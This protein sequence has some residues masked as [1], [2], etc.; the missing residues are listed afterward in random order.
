[1][2]LLFVTMV[3]ASVAAQKAA[4]V[5]P[6]QVGGVVETTPVAPQPDTAKI[7]AEVAQMTTALSELMASK[8]KLAAKK[9][10]LANQISDLQTKASALQTS[11]ETLEST[12]QEKEALAQESARQIE[13]LEKEKAE[14]DK[15]IAVI[16]NEEAERKRIDD[17]TKVIYQCSNPKD[18]YKVD[19]GVYKI[20]DSSC[21]L[22]VYL[23]DELHLYSVNRV[24]IREKDSQAVVF[25]R[26]MRKD[27]AFVRIPSASWYNKDKYPYSKEFII[28]VEYYYTSS[29]T[30]DQYQIDAM[31]FK[32]SRHAFAFQ[33]TAKIFTAWR[34]NETEGDASFLL[35]GVS[36]GAAWRFPNAEDDRDV[37]ALRAVLALGPN[38]LSKSVVGS[39]DSDDTTSTSFQIIGGFEFVVAQYLTIGAA[40][41]L[42]GSRADGAVSSNDPDPVPLLLVTYGELYPSL[43]STK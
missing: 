5:T 40:W 10:E 16:E 33:I 32:M 6:T 36:I 34:F 28:S 13:S 11:V 8:E 43:L 42:Q 18:A 20:K 27:S 17:K 29:G 23:A 2:S 12:R 31:N 19:D 37:L 22:D 4:D 14:L 30:A 21:N 25:E 15:K 7:A 35:P 41:V 3:P 9:D 1:A 26:Q 38:L 39:S 24:L